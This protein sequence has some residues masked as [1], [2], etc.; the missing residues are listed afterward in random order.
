M[1]Q[2]PALNIGDDPGKLTLSSMD[3]RGQSR[4]FPHTRFSNVEDTLA[5]RRMRASYDQ[6]RDLLNLAEQELAAS[7]L[8]AAIGLLQIA[9]RF[10]FPGNVGLMVSHRLEELL[11]KAGRQIP[12]VSAPEA[13][14]RST[15]SRRVLHVLSYGRPVGG[16]TRFVWRWIQEDQT[17][18]HF[19]AITT[20]A[21]VANLY[22]V[23]AVL[24][25]SA[26]ASG[27]FL[28]TLS[29]PP[30][31]PVEQAR[32]LRALCQQM[33]LVVLHLFP[34]DIIP[35][36]ALAAGCD[37]VKT[38]FV[39]HSDHTFWAGA[40]VAH[41]V[42]HLRKQSR[43][44]LIERR[45][46]K[47]E[48]TPVLPIPLSH[49]APPIAREE[50]KRALGYGP[51]TVVLLTIAS[52][53]KYSSPN[54]IGFLELVTPVIANSLQAVLIAVGPEP[55]GAWKAASAAT[56]GRIVPLGTTWDTGLLYA[57]AD[58]YLDSVPFSSITSLVEA[59]S[60]GCA[61]L[62]YAMPD[63]EISLLGPG[64]PG[65]DG[66]MIVTQHPE[67]YRDQCTRLIADPDYRTQCGQRVQEE[68][69][70]LH[71]GPKWADVVQK[72]YAITETNSSG[73]GC[74]LK[75]DDEFR[76]SSL[77]ASLAQLYP[78]RN[79]RSVIGK[80]LGALP[81]QSGLSLSLALYSKGFDLSYINLLPPSTRKL[82]KLCRY[83]ARRVS[84]QLMV[85]RTP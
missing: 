49:S 83:W 27:G 78:D 2:A 67:Q 8:H 33:D 10:A 6:F 62:G 32:E 46:L 36:L 20:Q 40:S 64:A 50:A 59:G 53:F 57:A 70:S 48:Q 47:P 80:Y 17:S 76:A 44:F 61:L 71:T 15:S 41:S 79:T 39:N 29:A 38:L 63:G 73:R 4:E 55:K 24:R 56:Q 68:I 35:V 19:V 7:N 60:H 25:S 11:G 13:E 66:T 58:I 65:I 51:E 54:S 21:D 14:H 37:G 85:A 52:P 69:L 31:N 5:L 45:G 75:R 42:V 84:R 74:L 18:Q 26:E 22:D 72:L 43:E 81:Y 12:N 82:A 9:A 28:R 34:Y 30:A 23:P 3:T 77:N 1:N 16:D